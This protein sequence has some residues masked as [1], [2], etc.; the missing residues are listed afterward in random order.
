M[1]EQALKC[2]EKA[3]GVPGPNPY[4]FGTLGVVLARTGRKAD[5]AAVLDDLLAQNNG[6]SSAIEEAVICTAINE[7]SRACDAIEKMIENR[8][9]YVAWLHVFPFFANL[10]GNERFQRLLASRVR[11]NI[12]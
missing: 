9:P 7:E 1:T 6:R 2:A 11:A 10:R 12:V 3:R 8:E 5:A 4:A